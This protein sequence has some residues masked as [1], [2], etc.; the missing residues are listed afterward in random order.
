MTDAAATSKGVEPRMEGDAVKRGRGEQSA[1]EGRGDKRRA[2]RRGEE[3]RREERRGQLT[4]G[5]WMEKDR[6]RLSIGAL[7]SQN[8]F[9]SIFVLYNSQKSMN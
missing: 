5:R 2:E 7:K 6:V 8:P 4:Q 3:K 1:A 9:G